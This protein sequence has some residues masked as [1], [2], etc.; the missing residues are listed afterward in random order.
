[1]KPSRTFRIELCAISLE[2]DTAGRCLGHDLRSCF[3]GRRWL[4][5]P[6]VGWVGGF[7]IWMM[8]ASKKGAA[9]SSTNNRGHMK[10]P[11]GRPLRQILYL[12]S[13]TR[14]LLTLSYVDRRCSRYL[15]TN[16]GAVSA[17]LPRVPF[18]RPM[19]HVPE[20]TSST[21][22]T[23]AFGG[24]GVPAT[25]GRTM[26]NKKQGPRNLSMLGHRIFPPRIAA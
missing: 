17:A 7:E 3:P 13:V 25:T 11:P 19:N 24:P 20:H 15:W 9:A 10:R 16:P 4:R 12:L 22:Y 21:P 14:W 6:P 26:L 1:M 23:Q 5:G 8:A 18:V 2:I